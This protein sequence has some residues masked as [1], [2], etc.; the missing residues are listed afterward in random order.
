MAN[1]S[2][3]ALDIYDLE[4]M[5]E[6]TREFDEKSEVSS[7]QTT[8][9]TSVFDRLYA[10]SRSRKKTE[11]KPEDQKQKTEAKVTTKPLKQ[12]HSKHPRK[13]SNEPST[14]TRNEPTTHGESDLVNEVHEN[15]A[16]TSNVYERLY[17]TSTQ[18]R[19]ASQKPTNEATAS[20][21]TS[22]SESNR[23][24]A[25]AGADRALELL[26]VLPRISLSNLKSNPGSFHR[27]K[28]GAGQHG[29]DKHGAGNK[30]SGQRQNFMRLGYETGNNPF[31]LRFSREP[32]YK[33]H[34]LR[35]EYPPLSLLQLQTMIDTGRL[36]ASKPI[37]LTALCN[38]KLFQIHPDQRQYG[39]QLTDEGA[40]VFK[41][42]V[43]IEVQWAP[44][45]V[46]AA[47]ERNGGVI[48]TAFYDMHSL[49][50]VTDPIK[51]FR[52]GVA[53]PKRQL[54]PEDMAEYYADPKFRGYLADPD[55]IAEER[56]RLSQKYGYILPDLKSD[57]QLDMLLERKDAR[58]IFYGL[59]PGW[60]INL[61]DKKV[62]APK[63]CPEQL[64][65]DAFLLDQES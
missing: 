20:L 12:V 39:I 10:D 49:W 50:A 25:V 26:R 62:L 33:G 16:T 28:R 56:F 21:V 4:S 30:G 22:H 48:T 59:Q 6:H 54:P 51:F 34:H 24:S 47:I 29:G 58:Q 11:T 55:L 32:Y 60:L 65:S 15:S 5:T 1:P 52:K 36:D 35:R 44:E 43:N 23:K 31:Y 17:R 13:V 14:T 40:D 18:A 53:I 41:A 9:R 63:T 61:K 46:I 37:D 64:S 45:Q 7:T 27:T 38:T 19:K 8:T 57:P 42:K 2:E 3:T